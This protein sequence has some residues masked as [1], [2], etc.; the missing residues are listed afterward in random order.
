MPYRILVVD[1]EPHLVRLMEFILAK[2]GHSMISA[3]NGRE[4][5]EK[6]RSERPDLILLDIMMPYIDGYE[7][8]QTLRA[9]DE[10]KSIPIILLSAKAQDEDIQR[11]L[12]LGVDEYITKPFSPEHLVHVV[13][14]YLTQIT[15]TE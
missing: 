3:V 15:P 12:D 10:I 5:L 8:A 11:G 1:D 7:V 2:Q 13:N 9:D 4:A 14:S 6:A